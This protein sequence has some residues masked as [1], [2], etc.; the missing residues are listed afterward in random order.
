MSKPEESEDVDVPRCV[1]SVECRRVWSER[2]KGP[3]CGAEESGPRAA[4]RG[5]AEM[6]RL[7]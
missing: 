7:V 1:W 5:E 6:G 3:V 4:G 2:R